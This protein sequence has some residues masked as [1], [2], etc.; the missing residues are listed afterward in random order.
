[1]ANGQIKIDGLVRLIALQFSFS[2]KDVIP[3]IGLQ[4]LGNETFR[5][6]SSREQRSPLGTL[7]IEPQEQSSAD[8]LVGHLVG[9]YTLVDATYQTRQ[10]HKNGGQQYHFVRFLFARNEFANSSEEFKAYRPAAVKALHTLLKEAYWRIRAHQNPFFEN[11]SIVEDQHCINVDFDVRVP[12]FRPNG[13]PVTRWQKD[14]SGERIGDKPLPIDATHELVLLGDTESPTLG[15][16]R[17]AYFAEEQAGKT[18][19]TI[20]QTA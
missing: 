13:E 6:A 1:M 17:V 3:K 4:D 9:Q 5:E 7:E 18:S 2:R 15:L 11:G 12:R 19:T 16:V 8:F 14:A 10:N 20:V